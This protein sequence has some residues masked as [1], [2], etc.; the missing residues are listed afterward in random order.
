MKRRIATLLILCAFL[1]PMFAAAVPAQAAEP[2]DAFIN[3]IHYDNSGADT[4]EAVEI[5]G[6]AGTDLTGWSIVLYNGNGGAKYD[7]INLGGTIPDQQNGFGTLHFPHAGIQNGS[8]DGF[9]L[10]DSGNM[11]LQFLSYEGNFTAVGGPADGM[12]STDIGV[13]QPS[14]TPVGDSLQL[15]GTGAVYEDFNWNPNAPNTFASINTGQTFEGTPPENAP[16]IPN[17]GPPLSVIEGNSASQT[18]SA[19]DEDGIVT[20]INLDDVDPPS[21][22]ISLTIVTPATEVGGT[23]TATVEVAATTSPGSYNVTIGFANDDTVPQTAQCTFEVE[24]I[25]IIPIY[26]IQGSG[27]FSPFEGQVVATTGVVTLF[28]ANGANFWLQDADGDGNPA[29]SDGIFAAGGGY[30]DIGP[31]PA[32]GDQIRIVALV[33]EQ[34]FGN[35]LPLTRLRNVGFIEIISSGN[36]LLEPVTLSDLPDESIAEGITFWEPLEGMLVSVENAPVVAA[37]SGF[38]EFAM[39]TKDDAKPGSGF[40]PET[41]QILIRS[42]GD[43]E[44][45]YNPERVLVDDSTLAEAINV[46]PGDRV[47]SLVGVVDYTFGNYKLQPDSFDVKTHNLPNLPASTRDGSFGDTAITT[48]NVE[49]LFDLVLNTPEVI[50]SFG[51]VGENPGSDGWSGGGITTA[52][53]TLRRKPTICSGDTDP[54][55]AFDPSVE[56]YGFPINTFDGLGSH[57]VTCGVTSGLII[58]EYVEGSSFNKAVEIYNGTGSAVNLGAAN[59]TV[60]IYFNGSTSAGQTIQLSGTLADGD[61]YVLANPGADPAILNVADQVSGGVLWNGNDAITLNSGGKDDASSTPTLE[62]LETQ[63]TKLALAIDVEL[64][65]PEIIVAQ[66]VENTAIL[67]ELGDRVNAATGT[68]YQAVSFETSDARGI[69]VGFLWDTNRVTLDEAYQMSGPD[70]E[71]AFGPS[72]DSPGREPL[73]GVFSIE[74]LPI[75]IV[76]NHFKSKGG[77]DPLFSVYWPP[78]RVTEVQRKKQAQVVRDYVNEI[79]DVDPNALVMVAGDLNDFQFGEPGEGPDHPVAIL[80]GID[81]EVPLINLVNLEKEPERFT[82]AYDGNSQVLDHMLVS[83][84][85]LDLFV[86]V[87]VLHFN[88]S[89]PASLGADATTPISSSDH[90]PLEGR[91]V[92]GK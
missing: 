43:N 23:A 29:T 64:D 48:F 82:Y 56:W 1:I 71:S 49:N 40:Y 41:E 89:Y 37:T 39:L 35:A 24:V 21:S 86:G 25:Q 76:G 65:L 6:P 31:R 87:D 13:S 85:L 46:M 38:G 80:E 12:E 81:E 8:P 83:P 84:A 74:G 66:E 77:D 70:V 57:A 68:N 20:N 45:D 28:T 15:S 88:A 14:D 92:F 7:T 51:K 62:E 9:A 16:I 3:E 32:V 26:D 5:A 54:S 33:D 52:N 91:F 22:D 78:V 55:D 36:P 11:V 42:L 79:L 59:V 47:R 73:V 30:P 58:S 60:Q 53:E 10:V 90:D 34:Q 4:G 19:S 27:Q 67:Q 69:E 17:C 63:L 18:V 75:T 61:V 2:G 72:S 44:V 50:D